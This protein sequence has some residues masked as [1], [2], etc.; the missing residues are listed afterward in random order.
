M[1]FLSQLDVSR[2]DWELDF[3]STG[4]SLVL[5]L[6]TWESPSCRSEEPIMTHFPA[7]TCVTF[8][9]ISLAESSHM[10]VQRESERAVQSHMTQFSQDVKNQYHVYMQGN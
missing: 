10:A 6:G 1:F 9:H 2:D 5:P 4:L 7:S 3:C 8:A